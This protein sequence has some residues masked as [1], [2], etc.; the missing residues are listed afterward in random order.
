MKRPSHPARP[1]IP[2]LG[3]ALVA[4]LVLALPAAAAQLVKVRAGAHAAIVGLG[5]LGSVAA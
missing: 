2:S 5:A 4:A 1:R 3:I